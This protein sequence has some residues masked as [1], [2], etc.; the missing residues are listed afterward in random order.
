MTTS[1]TDHMPDD[2][3]PEDYRAELKNRYGPIPVVPPSL[4]NAILADARQHLSTHRP[5]VVRHRRWNSLQWAAIA[6]T[7]AAASVM[8][9]VCLPER[10]ERGGTGNMTTDA[11]TASDSDINGD[12]DLNGRI[13]I[14]DAF[15]LARQIRSGEQTHDINRD[16]RFDELD[17]DLVAQ[18]AVML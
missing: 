10:A 18:R 6:T 8:C 4:E 16:G 13:D 14:R 11:S 5:S 12:V 2:G 7:V 17:V 9:I 1:D 3:L 15:A